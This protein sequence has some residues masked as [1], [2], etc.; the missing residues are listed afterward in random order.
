MPVEVAIP[1]TLRRY[2]GNLARL[3]TVGGPLPT[4]LAD[5]CR[6]HPALGDRL[7]T[8]E[9]QLMAHLA[10]CLHGELV[11]RD[12]MPET[13]VQDGDLLEIMFVASGG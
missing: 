5:L 2:S 13:L 9:G 7:L 8:A 12:A 10:V 4:V 6:Q 1:E 3:E 11:P